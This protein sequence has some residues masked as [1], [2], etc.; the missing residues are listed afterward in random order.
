VVDSKNTIQS[1]HDRTSDITK[2]VNSF[3]IV[4]PNPENAML[5]SGEMIDSKNTLQSLRTLVIENNNNVVAN[6]VPP[7]DVNAA[8]SNP[9]TLPSGEV[10]TVFFLQHANK[11]NPRRNRTLRKCK[12]HV[13]EWQPSDGY[14][15]TFDDKLFRR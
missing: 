5:P 10:K 4:S 11:Y 12:K 14:L 2:H 1:I 13:Y 15:A 8:S 9:P 3:A 7:F 6:T